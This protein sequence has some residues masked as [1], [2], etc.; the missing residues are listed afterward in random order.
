MPRVN[1]VPSCTEVEEIFNSIEQTPTK[2]YAEEMDKH[3]PLNRFRYE[4]N[5]PPATNNSGRI[6][7]IYFHSY[8]LGLQAKRTLS[9][10][11][12]ACN[13]WGRL[14]ARSYMEGK[15]PLTLC[16]NRATKL[17]QPI[18]GSKHLSEICLMNSLSVNTNL[19][20][21]SFYKP[22][23]QRYKIL[24]ENGSFCSD[25]HVIQGQLKLHNFTAKEALIELYPTN[26]KENKYYISNDDIINT[27][28]KYNTSIALIWLGCTQYLSGQL[29]DIKRIV[30][31]A[32]KYGIYV[33]LDLAH[34]IGNVALHLSDWNVDCAVFCGYKYLCGSG[35]CIGGI[36]VHKMHHNNQ[37]L[38][39]LQGWWGQEMD[40]IL[41]FVPEYKPAIG[42]RSW[43]ISQ[44]PFFE[45]VALESALEIFDEANFVNLIIKSKKLTKYLEILIDKY[46]N[47]CDIKI[48]TPLNDKE[49]GCQ[50]SLEIM[51]KEDGEKLK[52]YLRNKG[53]ICYVSK[54][55]NIVRVA[56]VPLYNMFIECWDFIQILKRYFES[57]MN[58]ISM[59]SKL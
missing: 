15:R 27:I 54:D 59:N 4:F 50:L 48:V 38:S 41:K 33:G 14:G 40:D 28:H 1:L 46:L 35:G 58:E 45:C 44:A 25:Q 22:T 17:L 8:G 7:S 10:L 20:M 12:E 49:R 42:A 55:Q 26:P 36:F 23:K 2:E 19:I 34:G 9:N 13:E 21:M 47:K 11:Q 53:V 18:I 32:H 6:E 43:A 37:T 30:K 31:I 39:K 3:D 29:F 5:I 56:P 51:R 24:I 52:K 57:N 16:E